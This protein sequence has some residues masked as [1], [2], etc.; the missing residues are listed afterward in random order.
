MVSEWTEG[1]LMGPPEV[2][3]DFYFRFALRPRRYFHLSLL[4]FE[5]RREEV[6][7]GGVKCIPEDAPHRLLTGLA[8]PPGPRAGAHVAD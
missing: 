1:R 5:G 6:N 2:L 7:K 8:P 3:H 4:K